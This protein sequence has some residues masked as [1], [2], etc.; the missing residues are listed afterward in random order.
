MIS[1]ALALGLAAA[2]TPAAPAQP[3]QDLQLKTHTMQLAG[4]ERVADEEPGFFET[5]YSMDMPE[6]PHPTLD[7][8]AWVFFVSGLG[9]FFG[10]P[11]W[12]P[13]M[14]ID[15]DAPQLW[16]DEALGAW[17]AHL[18]ISCGGFICAAIPTIADSYFFTPVA[19]YNLYDRGLKGGKQ[20]SVTVAALSPDAAMAY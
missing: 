18:P 16:Q 12:C 19:M 9:Q 15:G 17:A 5:H 13:P 3:A 14:L 20:A 8:K 11:V 6:N 7:G 4:V 2:T 1:V 10:A